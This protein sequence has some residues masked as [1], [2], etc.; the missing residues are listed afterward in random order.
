M[1]ASDCDGVTTELLGHALGMASVLPSEGESSQVGGEPMGAAPQP[2]STA[3]LL[4]Q[5]RGHFDSMQHHATPI[6]S[7]ALT[8]TQRRAAL[9]ISERCIY[10]VE[11]AET[12]ESRNENVS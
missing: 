5:S 8:A 12:S 7:F 3:T 4:T 1:P 9:L 6:A 2:S 11:A 10:L